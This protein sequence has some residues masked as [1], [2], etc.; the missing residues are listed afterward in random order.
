MSLSRVITSIKRYR[1]FSM[2]S[3]RNFQFIP[4]GMEK[5]FQE[6]CIDSGLNHRIIPNIRSATPAKG[7]LYLVVSDEDL[8]ELIRTCIKKRWKLGRDI[9]IISYDETPLK[10]ILAGGITVI[11]TDF[12][13]MGVTASDMV[14]GKITGKTSN[15]CRIIRRKSL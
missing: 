7:D 10:S 14:K 5:G 9:G 13:K 15:P 8:I 3:N 4:E 1:R 2:I 6:F 12:K 11:T